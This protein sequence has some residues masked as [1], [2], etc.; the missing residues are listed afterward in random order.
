MK[1]RFLHAA[2]GELALPLRPGGETVVGR[3]G[4]AADIELTWDRRISRRHAKLWAEGGYV[5]F[6][7]LGSRNGSWQGDTRLE[8]PIRLEPGASV[9]LGETALVVPEEQSE[10]HPRE[11]ERTFEH[12]PTSLVQGIANAVTETT[13]Q[14]GELVGSRDDLEAV[15]SPQTMDLRMTDDMGSG[16][17]PSPEPTPD[18]ALPAPSRRPQLTRPDRVEC[19]VDRGQ[20][21]ELWSQEISKG[22]LYVQTATPPPLG[23]RVEIRL[24]TTAGRISLQSQVVTVVSPER[25]AAFGM[26]PGVG[27]QLSDLSAAKRTAI[28][29]YVSGR[30]A[31]LG[32]ANTPSGGLDAISVEGA[33]QAARQLL[34]EADRDALY[35]SLDVNPTVVDK[36]LRELL[37]ARQMLF[38]QAL[39][40]ATPPQA[41][42]LQAAL[43]VLERMRRV[44]LNPEARL[45]HDFRAGH[46]RAPERIAAASEHRGP[47]LAILRRVWNR[48][49]PEQ[50][51]EA[52]RLTRKAFAARQEQDLGRAVRYGRRALELNPFFEELKKTVDAWERLQREAERPKGYAK[53]R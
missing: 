21:G 14:L 2:I 53:S 12:A 3:A 11:V 32:H 1:V 40:A 39:P 8:G 5:W 47:P 25:S 41:A 18:T 34:T 19:D 17:L 43:T 6:Q 52:A 36:D 23:S 7:D 31:A 20:L 30:T 15:A 38:E 10:P 45:E 26:P 28:Q 51:D 48:V 29:D 22:G 49:A 42:R 27:L 46:V 4:A 50:V 37:A 44:L 13:M 33:L 24:E 35:K 9:L 16:D